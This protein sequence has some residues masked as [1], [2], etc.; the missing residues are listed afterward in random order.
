[1]ATFNQALFQHL[2]DG[3]DRGGVVSVVDEV[4]GPVGAETVGHLMADSRLS[5]LAAAAVLNRYDVV[6]VQHEYGIYAGRDGDQVLDVL[7]RLRVPVIVVLHTVLGS[8]TPNQRLVLEQIVEAADA[9]VV[10][11]KTAAARLFE[12]YVINA[13]KVAA[14][15]HGAPTPILQGAAPTRLPDLVSGAVSDVASALSAVTPH[16]AYSD[17]FAAFTARPSGPTILSWGLLGPGKGLEWAIEALADLR[18]LTPAPRYVIAGQTHPKVLEREGEAYRTSLMNRAV[19]LG[20]DSMVRFDPGY[21]DTQSLQRLVRSADVVLLP[22]DSSEQATSGVLIEAVAAQRPVVATRFPHACE[23]LANG[24]GLL[25]GHRDPAGIAAALRRVLTE[26]ALAATM[27]A[28]SARLAPDLAW[29]AV[30]AQY[31]DLAAGLLA[32]RAGHA[33]RIHVAAGFAA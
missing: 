16:S 10:M 6:I 5:M 2:T 3:L 25:V 21:R 15:T 11:S 28:A 19:A 32:A 29:P 27:T 12:K 31:R 30:A 7:H 9:V 14:I 24:S 17:E 18:D 13:A 26:P 8:P 23:L 1:M 4:T 33:A 20:V 22:Y